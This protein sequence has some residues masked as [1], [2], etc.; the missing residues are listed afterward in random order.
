MPERFSVINLPCDV[1]HVCFLSSSVILIRSVVPLRL[2]CQGRRT[3]FDG[4]RLVC[5]VLDGLLGVFNLGPWPQ[6]SQS[7]RVTV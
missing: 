7:R 5:A 2:Q 6:R 4:R 3:T 1:T